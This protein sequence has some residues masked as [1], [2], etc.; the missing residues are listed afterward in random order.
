MTFKRVGTGGLDIYDLQFE[1]GS[2]EWRI[3][4]DA[5]GKI[6]DQVFRPVP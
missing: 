6:A 2:L 5:H 1:H 3:L 4:L